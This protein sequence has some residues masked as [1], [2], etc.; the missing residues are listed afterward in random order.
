MR[1]LTNRCS[2]RERQRMASLNLPAEICRLHEPILCHA[3]I[4]GLDTLL[5]PPD[6]PVLESQLQRKPPA[7]RSGLSRLSKVD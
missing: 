5:T 3:P 6:D 2:G 7:L 4:D 1:G